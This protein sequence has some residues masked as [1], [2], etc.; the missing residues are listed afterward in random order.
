MVKVDLIHN[1]LPIYVPA[2]RF[3]IKDK[4]IDIKCIL[5]KRFGTKASAMS[6]KLLNENKEMI[7]ELIDDY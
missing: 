6:I 1:Y 7:C 4:V 2:V 3:S 5:E